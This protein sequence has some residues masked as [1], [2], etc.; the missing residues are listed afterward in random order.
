MET[1]TNGHENDQTEQTFDYMPP[2]PPELITSLD[3]LLS[4]PLLPKSLLP[5]AEHDSRMLIE[6][7]INLN[8][9]LLAKLLIVEKQLPPIYFRKAAESA[10]IPPSIYRKWN[11]NNWPMRHIAT[12]EKRSQITMVLL[13]VWIYLWNFPPTE[14]YWQAH[15]R[16]IEL[17][18]YLRTTHGLSMN[19]IANYLV[20][21]HSSLTDILTK[22]RSNSKP[23]KHCPWL[24]I[25][26]LSV[27]PA[28]I[29]KASSG[30]K[31]T[32]FTIHYTEFRDHNQELADRRQVI[33]ALKRQM[34]LSG[35]DCPK[36]GA[37]WTSFKQVALHNEF[38]ELKE[39]ACL[40]CGKTVF[41]GLIIPV[42][43][44]RQGP[45]EHCGAPRQN[46]HKEGTNKQGHTVMLC[47]A[48]N[49]YSYRPAAL[50]NQSPGE[51]EP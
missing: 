11:P 20:M 37:A 4:D 5:K 45:C 9:R 35:D 33:Q 32:P 29:K 25:R 19:Q 39:Y 18:D 50:D 42:M 17:V 36:C 7:S 2:T 49:E 23:P 28:E 14:T 47:K 27:P 22:K 34:V 10:G 51:P 21:Q 3:Q 26:R 48:C 31:K 44:H 30:A 15:E 12:P 13:L 24:I 41:V 43:I 16:L 38:R 40:T 46:L 6:T 1:Q 8:Y